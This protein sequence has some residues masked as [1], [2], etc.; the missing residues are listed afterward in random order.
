MSEQESQEID[1]ER[2]SSNE[3]NERFRGFILNGSTKFSEGGPF[4]CLNFVNDQAENSNFTIKIEAPEDA[5]KEEIE[6][7]ELLDSLNVHKVDVKSFLE[8]QQRIAL[9]SPDVRKAFDELNSRQSC[10]GNESVKSLK[11]PSFL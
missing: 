4:L 3:S 5:S 1:N 11:S 6:I 10:G 9:D 8:D 2:D 7:H